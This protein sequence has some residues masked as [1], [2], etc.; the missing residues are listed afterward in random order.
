MSNTGYKGMKNAEEGSS[1]HVPPSGREVEL[2][3]GRDV[4]PGP[5]VVVPR[6]G[7]VEVDGTD[8]NTDTEEEEKVSV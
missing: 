6:P 5:V 3:P 2:G 7:E 1:C 8:T 4:M